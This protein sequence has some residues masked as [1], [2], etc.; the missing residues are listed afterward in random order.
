MLIAIDF[1]WW[2]QWNHVGTPLIAIIATYIAAEQ[3]L[4][5]RRQYRLALFEKRMAIFNSTATMIASVVQEANV[6]IPQCMK[7]L[8]DTR[9]NEFLFG[10]EVADFINEVYREAT[11]LHAFMAVN[12]AAQAAPIAEWFGG[13]IAEARKV[14][15]KYVDFRKP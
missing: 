2:L 7:F 1:P 3:F 5:N 15:G 13:Q 11:K 6:T 14:F 9:D 8:Q 12:N 4:V 10:K